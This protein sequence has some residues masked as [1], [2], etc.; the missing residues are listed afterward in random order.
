MH[1][2]RLPLCICSFANLT[3]VRYCLEKNLD[4]LA[5]SGAHGSGVTFNISEE[6][7]VINLRGLNTVTVDKAKNEVLLGGGTIVG[8][9]IEAAYQSGV[10]VG[11]ASIHGSPCPWRG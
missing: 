8:E 4:F 6:D 11:K 9:I 10:R 1:P 2:E 7:V 3:K 5:Q